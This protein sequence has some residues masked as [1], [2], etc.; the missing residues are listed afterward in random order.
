[1][2]NLEDLI[3]AEKSKEKPNES[4]LENLKEKKEKLNC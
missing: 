4:R 2:D 1:M 3:I